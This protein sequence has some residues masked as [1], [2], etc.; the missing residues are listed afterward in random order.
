[1]NSEK[2][3]VQGY[4]DKYGRN[5]KMSGGIDNMDEYYY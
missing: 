3:K 5:V 1:L 2:F 4:V